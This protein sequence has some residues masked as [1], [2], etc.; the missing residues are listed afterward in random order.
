MPFLFFVTAVLYSM[1]GLGGG[2]TYLALLALFSFSY[3][4]MPQVSL[5]CNIIVVVGG[6]WFFWKSG[7]VRWRLIL[8]FVITSIP[9]AYWGGHV[10]IS[11][12]IFSL[13][14]GVS[15]L[16][17]ALRM[18]LGEIQKTKTPFDLKKIFLWALPMGAGLG[19][20]SGLVG[21]GGGI[22]LAPLLI[23]MGWADS[24]EAAAA[25]SVF[26]LL[27]SLSGLAGQYLKVGSFYSIQEI[28]PLL[29]AVWMGGQIGSRIGSQYIS[30]LVIQRVGACLVFFAAARLL[31]I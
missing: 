6:V 13:L 20:L 31:M 8:P 30:K 10:T 14:L 22:Y 29:I 3:A 18:L 5:M 11:K 1:V 7:Y 9:A 4:S 28:L 27:N 25:S 26:I 21:I 19:F 12:K 24:K 16:V 23:L 17:A 2:S 15:L